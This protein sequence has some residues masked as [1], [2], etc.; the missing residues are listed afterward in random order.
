MNCAS[1]LQRVINLQCVWEGLLI[2]FMIF[3]PLDKPESVLAASG[4]LPAMGGWLG[5]PLK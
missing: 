5:A 1:A 3:H 4:G 2:R